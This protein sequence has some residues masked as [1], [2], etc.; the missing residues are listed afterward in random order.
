MGGRVKFQKQK[1]G[2]KKKLGGGRG[3]SKVAK[4]KLRSGLRKG[5]EKKSTW[6]GTENPISTPSIH[7][8]AVVGAG[9]LW[10]DEPTQKFYG[11]G[12]TIEQQQVNL[13]KVGVIDE[14]K[15]VE[16]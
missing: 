10:P 6:D 4:Q 13:G 9:S 12:P 7:V 14:L 2:K 8:G 1:K 3:E 15:E 16:F 11:V 5:K